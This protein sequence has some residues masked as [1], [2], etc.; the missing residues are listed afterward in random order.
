M[1]LFQQQA[2]KIEKG[3]MFLIAVSLILQGFSWV[4]A[5]YEGLGI[6]LQFSRV[7]G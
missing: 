4:Q 1:I 3:L 7:I 5:W 2:V 6:L